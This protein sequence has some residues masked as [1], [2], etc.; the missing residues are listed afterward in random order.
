MRLKEE[1]EEKEVLKSDQLCLQ[2]VDSVRLGLAVDVLL[3]FI[4]TRLT[5]NANTDHNSTGWPVG[6]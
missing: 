5:P 4:Q 6:M 2:P 3:A 1:V